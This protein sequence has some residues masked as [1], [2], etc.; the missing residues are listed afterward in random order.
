ML[1]CICIVCVY[2]HVYHVS[3]HNQT[4]PRKSKIAKSAP[5]TQWGKQQTKKHS[6]QHI[7]DEFH[8]A[9]KQR[10]KPARKHIGINAQ[11]RCNRFP[12]C[13][14]Q[15]SARSGH[16]LGTSVG[17]WDVAGEMSPEPS[18]PLP[19]LTQSL[20]Y[21]LTHS[22]LEITSTHRAD[23]ADTG[24]TDNRRRQS[25]TCDDL[26]YESEGGR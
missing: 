6:Q 1:N 25:A 9:R 20:T 16:P 8:Q 4:F 22:I 18:F 12:M 3:I 21:V 2:T 24:A 15:E 10:G 19:S 26:A 11:K 5:G 7:S 13:F 23:P 14:V 17:G